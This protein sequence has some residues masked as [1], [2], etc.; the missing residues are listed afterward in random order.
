LRPF[1][2][3][4]GYLILDDTLL[5]STAALIVGKETDP[6]RIAGLIY[7]WVTENFRF[8]LGAVL[9]GTSREVL[10]DLNG[11]CSEAAVLTAALL[12]ASGVPARVAMGFA[13]VGRGVF[14]GHAWAEARL[15]EQWVGVDAALRQFPAGVG[16]VRL[17]A[18]DGKEDMRIAA[19]NLMIAVLSNLQIQILAAWKDDR[20]VPLRR[21]RANASEGA[22][23]FQEILKGMDR[24]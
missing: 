15:G 7:A 14:I 1:L 13:S 12:R 2:A 10:R 19:T 3:S 23:Y 21:Y 11:D 8:E 20:A 18:L 4:N 17:V 22:Q 6:A 24:R 5:T 9:F 16:R